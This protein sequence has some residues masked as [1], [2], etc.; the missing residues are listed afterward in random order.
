MFPNV[1]WWLFGI[2]L[3]SAVVVGAF[4]GKAH[5]ESGPIS[6]YAHK[7]HG[8]RTASGE[9]FDMHAST[10][11]HPSARFGTQYRVTFR[12]RSA[13]CRVNDRGPY[14][15]GR[16]LDVSLAVAKR[17]GLIGPGHGQASFQQVRF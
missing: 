10:C 7:H 1:I 2:A 16:V 17:L 14:A 13:D 8:K 3:A 15:R 5:A 4:N 11:A 12:G 9:R 6:Y